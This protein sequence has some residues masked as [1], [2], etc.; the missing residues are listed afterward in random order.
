MELI[1]DE[2]LYVVYR[3]EEE[4]VSFNQKSEKGID[5]ILYE[6]ETNKVIIKQYWK[7]HIGMY[8]IQNLAATFLYRRKWDREKLEANS[9]K[10]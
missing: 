3:N 1:R 10:K 2:F 7:G 6:N 5:I 9:V 4:T 8:I